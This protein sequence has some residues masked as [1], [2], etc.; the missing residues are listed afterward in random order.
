MYSSPKKNPKLAIFMQVSKAEV[1]SRHNTD[2]ENTGSGRG[3]D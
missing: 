3:R 2:F 1:I